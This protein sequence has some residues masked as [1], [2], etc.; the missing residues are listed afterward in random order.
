MTK[1]KTNL[2][3][4]I[5]S[6]AVLL[7]VGYFMG[8]VDGR[9]WRQDEIKQAK[10]SIEA[11]LRAS[12]VKAMADIEEAGDESYQNA[13]AGE[14]RFEQAYRDADAAF[15][16]LEAARKQLE[17]EVKRRVPLPPPYPAGKQ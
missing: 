4:S 10:A 2:L 15:K 12:H 9:Q 17:A 5:L 8:R 6:A 3:L 16:R 11:S 1:G 14:Q 7:S 13:V